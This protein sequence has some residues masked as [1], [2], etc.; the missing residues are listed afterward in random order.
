MSTFM[1]TQVMKKMA[2]SQQQQLS[3]MPSSKAIERPG[4]AHQHSAQFLGA[5]A[6]ANAAKLEQDLSNKAAETLNWMFDTMSSSNDSHLNR[7]YP[8]EAMIRS[9]ASSAMDPHHSSYYDT[10][11]PMYYTSQT[12]SDRYHQTSGWDTSPRWN[13]TDKLIIYHLRIIL[14]ETAINGKHG[15]LFIQL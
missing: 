14:S 3:A 6:Q 13:I 8:Q 11:R 9:T 4:P 2:T 15:D 1:P 10:G 7:A 12:L 5:A